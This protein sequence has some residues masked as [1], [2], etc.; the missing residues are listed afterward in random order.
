MG[1]GSRDIPQLVDEV[2]SLHTPSL[3]TVPQLVLVFPHSED[4]LE[5][6]TLPSSELCRTLVLIWSFFLLHRAVKTA[7]ATDERSDDEG[8]EGDDAADDSK[9]D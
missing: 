8:D 7:K 3:T 6:S 5:V 9:D 1:L 4:C 2:P